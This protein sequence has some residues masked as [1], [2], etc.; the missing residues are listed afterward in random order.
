MTNGYGIFK[1]FQYARAT[2]KDP[3]YG[4]HALV[5]MDG[6]SVAG[7]NTCRFLAS[8][9]QTMQAEIGLLNCFGISENTK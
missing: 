8:V 6:V 9:L 4:A 7:G 5:A 3:P 2:A 1:A